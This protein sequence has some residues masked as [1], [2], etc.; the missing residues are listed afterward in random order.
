MENISFLT[1]FFGWCSVLNLS[2]LLFSTLLLALWGGCVKRCHARIF[3]VPEDQLDRI[4]FKYLAHYKL[5]LLIFNLAPY[6]AL[7]IIAS[8]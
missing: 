2:V 1:T 3:N 8:S 7:K 6:F 4:Y 5:G